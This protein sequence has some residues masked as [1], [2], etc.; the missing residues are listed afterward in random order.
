[1]KL[2]QAGQ[3]KPPPVNPDVPPADAVI[4]GGTYTGAV[5]GDVAR[6]DVSFQMEGLKKGWSEIILPLKSVAVESVELSSPKALFSAK[7]ADYAVF[8]PEPGRYEAKLKLSARVSQEPGKKTISFGIPP[9]AVSKLDI[10]IPEE[11]VRVDVKPMLAVTQTATEEGPARKKATRVLAF[12]GNSS[13]VSVS[14]MPPAGKITEGGAIVFGE[15]SVRAYLGERILKISTDLSYQ[16]LRGEVDT[17]RVHLPDGTRLLSVKGENI[18]EWAQ[19]AEV[20]VVRLHSALKSGE[21]AASY[22]L[23]LSFERILADTPAAISVPFPRVEGVIRESGWAVLGHEAGLDVRINSST[24]LSQLDK[25]EVPEALRAD[26]GIGFR[27]LAQPLALELGVVKILPLVRSLATSVITIG[28]EEDVWVGWIDYTVTKSGLFRLEL[29]VPSRWNVAAVGDPSTTEDFQTTDANHV[30][31]TVVSLKSKALGSFRLPFRLVAQGSAAAGSITLSPPLV[32]GTS[33]DKGLL[34]VS[35]PKAIEL[36][37]SQREKMLPADVDELFRSGIMGQVG[38]DAGIPLTYSYREQPASVNLRLEPK[39]TEIDVLAQHLVEISDGGIKLT[40]TLDFEILYAAVDR[41]VFSAPSTLDNLLKVEAKEKK[42]VRKVSTS[43][44][45]TVW[46]I[47]LQAPAL[48]GVSV[49]LSHETELKALE[50]GKPFTY[51]VP[52]VHARE[53]RAEKGLVALRKEGTLEIV[54][55]PTSM[56][57][58]DA[59]ELSDKLRRGQIYGAFR[60][61]SPDPSLTLTLTKY[62]YQPLATTVVN[63]IHLKSILSEE[64]KLRTQAT[65]FVQNT[66]RQ[67]LEL[68]LPAGADILTASVAGKEQ[69]PRKRKDSTLLYIPPS[70]GPAGTFPIVILYDE[71]A[72]GGGMGALGSAGLTTPEVLDGVPVTKIE[73]ELYLPPS[74]AYLAFGG[75]L[76]ASSPSAPGLWPRF[77]SLLAG[78]V[79][80]A[81]A[82]A[83]SQA[84]SQPL[85][86]RSPGDPSRGTV[87]AAAI[88]IEIP[89]RGYIPQTFE[90]MAPVGTLRAY[91]VG[92][93]LY[94]FLDFCALVGSIAGAYCLLRWARWPKL[95]T[96][97]ALVFAPLL[98]V[99]FSSGAITEVFASAFLG[100]AAFFAF[101]GLRDLR[102]SWLAY[103]A[104]RRALA[105]DPFLE[106][107]KAKEPKKPKKEGS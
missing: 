104:S 17:L 66:E 27:Y 1:L 50:S 54:P 98:L 61:F 99:W 19:E 74:Y 84:A 76:K 15:Q 42:E 62:E 37:T 58:I 73:L 59:G 106:E 7:G 83:A 26:L 107:A 47:I 79:R 4:R 49:T 93:R 86:A 29:K 28:R 82:S 51:P 14:W 25:E 91:Y 6:F 38:A 70:A 23:S 95:Q 63:L 53:V 46:E 90:T 36:N 85:T 100:G 11:D 78:T 71:P 60:Y 48:G 2:W 105:P 64:R 57:P 39:K 3:P 68:K 80:G 102:G 20:L 55:Q 45:R 18:R 24:G 41:L 97:A 12:L 44:G 65:L 56:E 9:T 8:L 87:G 33:E 40:H 30:R 69:K 77:T 16:V 81:P 32:S 5:S 101:L 89:T 43:E 96:G 75:N 10:S 67:Y 34:G 92:R 88:D 22:K 94:S 21:P 13:E 52:I 31:S 35:A 72:P 103:R